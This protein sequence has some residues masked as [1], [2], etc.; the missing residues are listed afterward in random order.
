MPSMETSV[1]LVVCQVSDADC[2][3]WMLLGLTEIEAVGA[4]GGGG[5]GGGG[6]GATFFLQA[7]TARSAARERARNIHFMLLCFTLILL[8]GT[9]M[10]AFEVRRNYL[11]ISNSSSVASY[12]QKKSVVEPCCHRPAYSKSQDFPSGSIGTR[13]AGCPAT[14]MENRC[15][16]HRA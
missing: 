13:Y 10:I 9:S 5:G 8:T 4:A 14:T 15:A 11:F 6:G 12:D 1:A 2:P 3:A 16:R 7:P